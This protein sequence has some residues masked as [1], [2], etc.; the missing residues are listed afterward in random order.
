MLAG[1]R[2][3]LDGINLPCPHFTCFE[4]KVCTVVVREV[5]SVSKVLTPK[6]VVSNQILRHVF[7]NFS[8]CP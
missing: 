1:Q 3:S 8:K 5:Q 4:N 7:C 6:V 2:I